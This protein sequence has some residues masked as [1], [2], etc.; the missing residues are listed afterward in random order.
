MPIAHLSHRTVVHIGGDA[1]SDFLER[2]VTSDVEDLASGVVVPSALLT[3]QGKILFDFLLS[4]GSDGGFLADIRADQADDF[5]R[6]LT[7]YRLRAAV[8]LTRDDSLTVSAGWGEPAIPG[9][10]I[11]IRFPADA[12]VVRI[13]GAVPAHQADTD[14]WDRI[15]ILNGVAESGLDYALGDAFPHDVLM[16]KNGGVDFRKG[17]YVGQEVV[18]RMQH[19]GTARRRLVL[20][21]GALPLP[22][23]GTPVLAGE[24]SIGQ[25]GSV[26]GNYGL[27]VV[28]T[29]KVADAIAE[30][31]PL[32]AG[33]QKAYLSLPAWSGLDFEPRNGPADD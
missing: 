4:R 6:R 22:P 26:E 15:R 5:I 1:A 11:D 10:L 9:A 25:L 32:T 23:T 28:R 27:A 13:C 31:M 24:R 29:D 16:D 18:S 2:L 14:A 30:N 19:R 21:E 7:M 33:G 3:P 20:V 8:T 12:Q 17:C